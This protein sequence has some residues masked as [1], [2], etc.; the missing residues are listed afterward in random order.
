MHFFILYFFYFPLTQKC[1]WNSMKKS[2]TTSWVN[3]LTCLRLL[4]Y[5]LWLWVFFSKFWNDRGM[6]EHGTPDSRL[7]SWYRASIEQLWR[8]RWLRLLQSHS[9]KDLTPLHSGI[10]WSPLGSLRKMIRS[11]LERLTVKGCPTHPNSWPAIG[12]FQ[13]NN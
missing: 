8:V 2:R 7:T 9:W 6:K 13:V 3:P 12:K 1:A 11:L 4:I 5:S 10:S